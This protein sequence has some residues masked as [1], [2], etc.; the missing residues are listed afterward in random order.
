MSISNFSL[1]IS[2]LAFTVGLLLLIAPGFLKKLNDV[3]AKM[4]ARIDTLTFS[5]RIGF[6]ISLIIISFFMLF[7]SYYFTKRH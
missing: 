6:G 1:L 4:I 7:M 2:V 5:Y 3:S